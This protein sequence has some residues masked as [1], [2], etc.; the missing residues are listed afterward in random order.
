MLTQL[1]DKSIYLYLRAFLLNNDI[2]S[3][4]LLLSSSASADMS[5]IIGKMVK[6]S[7]STIS[8]EVLLAFAMS[9]LRY[10]R[11]H[12]SEF[13]QMRELYVLYEFLCLG[14]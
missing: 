7:K 5:F 9:L 6:D 13:L 8:D 11:E 10:D 2:P 12:L 1:S 4:L 3:N 14:A